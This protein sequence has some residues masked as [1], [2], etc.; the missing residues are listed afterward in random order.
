M[1]FSDTKFG[2]SRNLF[3]LARMMIKQAR[4]LRNS[5]QREASRRLVK[6]ARAISRLGWSSVA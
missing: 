4:M 1:N 5:G 3:I 2:R 6:R